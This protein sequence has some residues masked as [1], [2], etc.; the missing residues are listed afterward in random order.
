[1]N[2]KELFSKANSEYTVY[3]NTGKLEHFNTAEYYYNLYKA[4]KGKKII[5]NL[6]I[7]IE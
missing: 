4:N 7:G 6:E 2:L 1:M 5:F 3:M